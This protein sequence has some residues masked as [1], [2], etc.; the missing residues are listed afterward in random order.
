M[1]EYKPNSHLSKDDP[2]KV[3]GEAIPEKKVG[4]VVSGS[5]KTKKKSG[6][7]KFTDAFIQEDA[8]NVKSYIFMEVLVPALKKAISDVVTNGIDMILYG[9]MGRSKK[10]S[11]GSKV[12]YRNY[13]E[14]RRDD[15]RYAPT[16]PRDGYDYDD[17]ILPNRGEAEE[18]LSR[19]D[20]LIATYGLVSVADLYDLVGI[21][22]SYTDNKYG[23]TDIR[24]ASVVRVR[25]GYVIKLPR[26][27]PLN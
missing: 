20:E 26:A 10:N 5:V 22:G 27:L 14:D 3:E 6:L 24:N 12:S 9:E 11:P 17:I 18:V 2:K 13:Y 16:R 4:K 8:E 7:T 23:W 19:M 21:A 1:E 15:R 25:D